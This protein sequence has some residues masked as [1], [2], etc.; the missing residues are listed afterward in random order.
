MAPR[1][2]KCQKIAKKIGSRRIDKILQEIFT[3]EKQAY[4]CDEREYNERIA[5]LESRVDYRRGIIG[6]L[7]NHGFDAVVDEPLAVLKAAV[8]DDLAEISRLIQMSHLAAMRAT[9]K[10]KV[11]KK[12]KII[13]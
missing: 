1:F 6:E 10:S 2:P 3:R 13:K 8:L 9:E 7:Q 4:D 12:I 11:G 5:E